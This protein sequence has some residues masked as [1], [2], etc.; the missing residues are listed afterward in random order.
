[1]RLSVAW[2]LREGG[3]GDH[4]GGGRLLLVVRDDTTAA[5]VATEVSRRLGGA[6]VICLRDQG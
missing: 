3:G 4:G 2:E 5:E 1:M 6:E